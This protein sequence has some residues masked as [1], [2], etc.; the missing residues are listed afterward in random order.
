MV[1]PLRS[2]E[3]VLADVPEADAAPR[4]GILKDWFG[5]ALRGAA[6]D[7]GADSLVEAGGCALRL[8]DRPD[9][10][11]NCKDL[12]PFSTAMDPLAVLE[13]ATGVMADVWPLGMGEYGRG[14]DEGEKDETCKRITN[15]CVAFVNFAIS[16]RSCAERL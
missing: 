13:P 8:R 14:V 10:T 15:S 3:F 12:S 16:F 1:S 11:C 5:K 9:E 6:E 2:R 4:V 7:A